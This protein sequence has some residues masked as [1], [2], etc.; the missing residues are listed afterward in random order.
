VMRSADQAFGGRLGER[1]IGAQRVDRALGH[2]GVVALGRKLEGAQGIAGAE[3]LLGG[4]RPVAGSLE[5]RARVPRVTAATRSWRMSSRTSG[6][7]ESL[8]SAPPVPASGG[9]QFSS[10]SS[11]S[12]APAS[13]AAA[14]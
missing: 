3:R 14:G 9:A 6:S 10:S 5:K 7:T 1:G 11:S 8:W 13:G 2:R 4:V 12:G